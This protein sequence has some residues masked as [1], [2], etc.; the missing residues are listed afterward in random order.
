MA[1][2]TEGELDAVLTFD[3]NIEIILGFSG[4]YYIGLSTSYSDTDYF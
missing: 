3:K 1:S 4:K 2:I